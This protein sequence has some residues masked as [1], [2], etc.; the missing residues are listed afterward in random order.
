[1]NGA[2]LQLSDLLGVALAVGLFFVALN[3]RP[4]LDLLRAGASIV[5]DRYVARY[6]GTEDD[7]TSTID[8]RTDRVRADTYQADTGTAL[9]KNER[10][11]L[12]A[13]HNHTRHEMILFLSLEVD[14]EGDFRYSKNKIADFVGG[15]RADVLAEIDRCRPRSTPTP[16]TTARRLERPA[17]GW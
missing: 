11:D 9:E 6:D 1:M 16:R 5:S 10:D 13:G 8:D 2:Q 3:A 7:R 12:P 17:G 4:L 15:T 14:D